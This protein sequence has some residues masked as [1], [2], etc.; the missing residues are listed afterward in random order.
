MATFKGLLKFA[1]LFT[2]DCCSPLSICGGL[3]S[4]CKCLGGVGGEAT[5]P[6][7]GLVPCGRL[8]LKPAHLGGNKSHGLLLSR[9]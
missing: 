1:L 9:L 3:W 6:A 8:L 4:P 2:G 7:C 5:A